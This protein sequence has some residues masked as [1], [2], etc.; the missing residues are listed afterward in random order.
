LLGTQSFLV[1]DADRT[2]RADD[3]ELRFFIDV[4]AEDIRPRVVAHDIE[5]VLATRDVTQVQVRRQDLFAAK[6]R[7][8]KHLPQGVD[9]T[10][11]PTRKDGLRRIPTWGDVGGWVVGASRE[12]VA[13]QDET[14]ALQCDIDVSNTGRVEPSP[15]PQISRSEAV[16]MSLRCLPK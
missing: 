11:A 1:L 2:A 15:K 8:G 14:A 10:A 5:V 7:S 6:I 9:N 13:G 16:G 3:R 4:E 12:L